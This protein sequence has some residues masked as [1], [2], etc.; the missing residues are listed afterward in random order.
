MS[1]RIEPVFKNDPTWLKYTS[2]E[3]RKNYRAKKLAESESLK[4]SKTLKTTKVV[5]LLQQEL[6]WQLDW[7][8]GGIFEDN[9]TFGLFF[10][11]CPFHKQSIETSPIE[12]WTYTMF[13]YPK[14]EMQFSCK[15][16]VE[17]K[18]IYEIWSKEKKV[19]LETAFS[20]VN[21]LIRNCDFNDDYEQ[22]PQYRPSYGG[23]YRVNKKLIKKNIY[24]N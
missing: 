22:L 18:N 16:G 24:A 13:Y 6:G 11:I 15:C 17:F 9:Q 5:R 23:A 2:N 7:T 3:Y 19:D 4:R 10:F 21:Y 14:K 12:L 20:E 8:R 1:K